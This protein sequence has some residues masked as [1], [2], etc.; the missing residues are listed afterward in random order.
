[1]V[2]FKNSRD[3]EQD[4]KQK[5]HLLTTKYGLETKEAFECLIK[6]IDK[7]DKNDAFI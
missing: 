4:G 3:A 1:M 5:R 6:F 7:C 2:I